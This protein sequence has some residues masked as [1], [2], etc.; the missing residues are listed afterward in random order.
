MPTNVAA[1]VVR[2]MVNMLSGFVPAMLDDPNSTAATIETVCCAELATKFVVTALSA[3]T[4]Q[5]PRP[6]GLNVP[7]CASISVQ[8]PL[9]A[10]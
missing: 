1:P 2:S 7:A 8:G 5:S 6:V 9:I 3:C 10:E 4:T